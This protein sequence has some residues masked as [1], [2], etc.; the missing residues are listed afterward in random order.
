MATVMRKEDPVVIDT[1]ERTKAGKIMLA[2]LV[3][4]AILGLSIAVLYGNH[5]V[6]GDWSQPAA[7]GVVPGAYVS[8]VLFNYIGGAVVW[9]AGLAILG[10][11]SWRG[12]TKA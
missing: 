2:G 11:L 1:D 10:V 12:R 9:F 5:V 6:I 8:D 7:R 4:W 3:G